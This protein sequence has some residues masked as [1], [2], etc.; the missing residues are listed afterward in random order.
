MQISNIRISVAN[1]CFVLGHT[2]TMNSHDV[3]KNAPVVYSVKEFKKKKKEVGEGSME[4]WVRGKGNKSQTHGI[5]AANC[6]G[7]SNNCQL[8]NVSA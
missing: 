3:P 1:S 5:W 8:W 4:R 6:T 2:F 7:K